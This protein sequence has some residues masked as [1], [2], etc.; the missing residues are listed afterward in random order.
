MR[1]LRCPQCPEG[2]QTPQLGPPPPPRRRPTL[3]PLLP[4]PRLGHGKLL[5]L[6]WQ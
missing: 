1:L 5:A 4:D 2:A 3:A 6:S